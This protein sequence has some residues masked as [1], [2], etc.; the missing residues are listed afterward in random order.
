MGRYI[1]A[2]QNEL[3][4]K[5]P[6]VDG[7]LAGE[8]YSVLS[9]NPAAA[10]FKLPVIGWKADNIQEI[11]MVVFP[12]TERG[13]ESGNPAVE[14]PDGKV[15]LYGLFFG[16]GYAGPWESVAAYVEWVNQ[17]R[18][19]DDEHARL[20]AIMHDPQIIEIMTK[21]DDLSSDQLSYIAARIEERRGLD[22]PF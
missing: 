8:G 18:E 14:S 2:I 22:L 19:M 7:M 11:G 12:V 16:G 21:L 13:V 3:S 20:D 9:G 6:K 17:R 5:V 4:E 15:E 10:D 1:D